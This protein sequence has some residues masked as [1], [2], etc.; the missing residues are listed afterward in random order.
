[1]NVLENK[2]RDRLQAESGTTDITEEA[3]R[4][5]FLDLTDFEQPY[6]RYIL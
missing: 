6:F 1:V 2:R 4:A 5:K 3:E